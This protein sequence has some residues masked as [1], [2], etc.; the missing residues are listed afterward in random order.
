M[1]KGTTKKYYLKVDK[2]NE[3]FQETFEM[4]YETFPFFFAAKRFLMAL[5][6]K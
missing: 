1:E 4:D 5:C 2:K 6:A 3:N